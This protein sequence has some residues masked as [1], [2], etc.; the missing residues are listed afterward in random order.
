MSVNTQHFLTKEFSSKFQSLDPLSYFTLTTTNIFKEILAHRRIN[1]MLSIE[2]GNTFSLFINHRSAI[3]TSN[4]FYL[5]N[6]QRLQKG[7][8][9]NK[10][11]MRGVLFTNFL[12]SNLKNENTHTTHMYTHMHIGL[13]IHR[14]IHMYMCAYVRIYNIHTYISPHSRNYTNIVE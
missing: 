10:E 3:K 11:S 14:N 4:S 8:N 12:E 2:S 9:A 7:N 1:M 13:H 6:W 5:F